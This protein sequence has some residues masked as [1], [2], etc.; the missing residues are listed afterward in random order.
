MASLPLQVIEADA[1]RRLVRRS[2]L[3]LD[4][5]LHHV[6]MVD[7]IAAEI[8]SLSATG[9]L[10]ELAEEAVLPLLVEVEL[11][12]AGRRQAQVVWCS[13]TAAGCTFVVPLS[14]AEVAAARLKSAFPDP[15]LAPV[16]PPLDT[17]D[18]IWLT[19]QEATKAEKWPLPARA[20]LFAAAAILPWA[21]LAGAVMALT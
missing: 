17:A 12:R 1:D 7:C 19:A 20:A 14:P 8:T 16:L 4:V 21:S 11:P 3:S 6:G 2:E 15:D 9:F 10:A 5:T 18:P 13:E